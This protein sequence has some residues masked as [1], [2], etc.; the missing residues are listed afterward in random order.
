MNKDEYV[1]EVTRV[2]AAH[3]EPAAKKLTAL[4]Q[5]VPEKA[6]Q[7]T[8]DLYVY[9]GSEGFLDVRVGLDG[10][11]LNVLNRAISSHADLFNTTMTEHGMSPPLPLMDCDSEDFSVQDTLTDCGA[12]WVSAV[13]VKVDH[14]ACHFPVIVTS[15]EGYG[16][17][18]PLQLQQ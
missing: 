2:L 15:P 7:I 14:T 8:I 6:K 17:L 10:P 16:E 11:D 5:L 13:W 3:I 12:R 18:P 9:Q 1:R 4:L